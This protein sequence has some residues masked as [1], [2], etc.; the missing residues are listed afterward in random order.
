MMKRRHFLGAGL[1]APF[2]LIGKAKA[3]DMTEQEARRG[4]ITVGMPEIFDD[5]SHRFVQIGPP[6]PHATIARLDERTAFANL[7][8]LADHHP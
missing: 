4:M 5:G 6:I 2:F 7:G 8:K 3:L 1:I